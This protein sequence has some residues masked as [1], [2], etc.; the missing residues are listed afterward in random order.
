MSNGSQPEGPRWMSIIFGVIMVVY[1]FLI[2]SGALE[3]LMKTLHTHK[4]ADLQ[5]KLCFIL[6]G[7]GI[8][9]GLINLVRTPQDSVFDNYVLKSV[10]G[11][12]FLLLICMGILWYLEPLVKIWSTALEPTLKFSVFK[13]FNLNHIVLGIVVGIIITNTVG[14]PKFAAQGVKTARFV[15]KMGIITLGCRY[16]L[17]ELANLGQLSIWMIGFFVIG[18]VLLVLWLGKLFATPHS[19]TGVLSSGMGVCGVSAAVACAPVVKAKSHEMAYTIG[20]ILLWGVGC[21]FLFPTIGKILGMSPT[22]FGAWAGTGILN[23]AQVAAAALAFNAVDIATLKVAEIFNITRV[24]FLPVIVLILAY[25]YAKVSGGDGTSKKL[26]LK[27]V[28]IDKFPLFVLGFIAMFTLSSLGL[29]GPPEHY[30]GKFL[31]FSYNK[32]TELT[33]EELEVLGKFIAKPEN[34][35]K[36]SETQKAALKDLH[37]QRQ[38]AGNYEQRA[39]A[40]AFRAKGKE[41]LETLKSIVASK[42]VSDKQVVAALKHADKQVRKSSKTIVVLTDLMMWFFAYGLLGLGMQITWKAIS[43]AGGAPL[44]IGA[45]SGTLKAVLSLI[46]VLLLIKEVV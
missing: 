17:V 9:V 8:L 34:L 5:M 23:S 14:I 4:D 18:T 19:M 15:L 22:Q 29:F 36:L 20:T 13:I 25:W 38:I 16:S 40:A 28:V 6:G 32:R 46:A 3:G 27:D 26:S 2:R 39:D 37:A 21:M 7:I 45:I 41:R 44:V 35:A 42:T 31:D 12:M 43:Q 24:L 33:S 1:G 30:K 10:P 11:I